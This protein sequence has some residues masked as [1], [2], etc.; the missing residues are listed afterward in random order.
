MFGVC[1]LA[2]S[3]SSLPLAYMHAR[4]EMTLTISC[5]GVVHVTRS[6]AFAHLRICGCSFR[7]TMD[8]HAFNHSRSGQ[9]HFRFLLTAHVTRCL[10]FALF[11]SSLLS[12]TLAYV[13][14]S[15]ARC[16]DIYTVIFVCSARG[17]MICVCAVRG[18]TF[19]FY[20]GICTVEHCTVWWRTSGWRVPGIYLFDCRYLLRLGLCISFPLWLVGNE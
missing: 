2:G 18:F 17:A 15:S 7:V 6:L 1:A 13:H 5:W 10:A 12:L 14:S 16:G 11:A 8:I 4:S 9:S 3:I 19:K 20:I